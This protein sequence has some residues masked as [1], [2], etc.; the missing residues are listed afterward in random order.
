M[1]LMNQRSNQ[2]SLL[3]LGFAMCLVVAP[4]TAC[5]AAGENIG[6]AAA[7]HTEAAADAV[8]GR[9][10]AAAEQVE[11]EG[12][13]VE[14]ADGEQVH[15][16]GDDVP[17]RADETER[18]E[19]SKPME[20][21]AFGGIGA[22]DSVV[23]IGAGSGYNTFLLSG[24]VGATGEVIAERGNE[25]L[26]ARIEHG[27]L[28]EAGNVSMVES[29]AAIADGSADAIVL[30]REYHL[31]EDYLGLMADL[32]RILKDDGVLIVVEVRNSEAEGHDMVTHRLGEQTVLAQFAEGG[33]TLDSES[34][35]L[36]R[37]D[38]DYTV[39]GGP[40]GLRYVTDRMLMKFVKTR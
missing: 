35:I 37:D 34:E 30:I 11:A 18:D 27:D 33:F 14:A 31:V 28:A 15:P 38:D 32:S 5:G 2:W 20:V 12:E 17:T 10:E 16:A 39:Y 13:H 8:A 7:E 6:A 1:P 36:R 26:A 25:G 21:Y 3:T 22:G 24:V 19:Y 9:A 40:V 4:I 23:D 29:R